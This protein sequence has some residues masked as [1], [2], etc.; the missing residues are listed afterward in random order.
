MAHLATAAQ[1]A[2]H[3]A[4]F[5]EPFGIGVFAGQSLLDVAVDEYLTLLGV[6]HK[7]LARFESRCAFDI[8]GLDGEGSGLGGYHE[9]A[10][11]CDDHTRRA[12]TVAVESATGIS[13]VGENDGCRAIP[14]G[15]EDGVVLIE[16]LETAR[17]WVL[18][19]D[20]FR[21]K[22]S[23]RMWQTHARAYEEFQGIVKRC[24]V[25][26]AGLYHLADI[27]HLAKILGLNDGLACRHPEAVAAYGVDFAI[28]ADQAEW[29]G[30]PPGGEG[31]GREAGMHKRYGA[32]EVWTLQVF[33]IFAELQR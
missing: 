33:E 20:A 28:V 31:V 10:V 25:A 22:H 13:S 29:L 32:C 14:R 17:E 11:L 4:V 5:V 18:V 23:Q 15:H 26:H 21:H 6:D 24:T 12:Q 27:L 1:L 2:Q 3:D 7:N 30:E 8:L 16:C 19:I 9:F